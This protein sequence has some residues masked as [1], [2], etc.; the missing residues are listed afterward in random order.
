MR[1][2]FVDESYQNGV[3]GV[4]MVSINVSKYYELKE[5]YLECLNL[6]RWNHEEDIEFK[7]SDIYSKSK[8]DVSVDINSRVRI[9]NWLMEGSK[10]IKSSKMELLFSS[11]KIAHKDCWNF[12]YE[13]VPK[14]LEKTLSGK[15]KK[16]RGR[17]KNICSIFLDKLGSERKNAMFEKKMAE[18]IKTRRFIFFENIF[19]VDS[20]VYTLGIVYA[21][22]IVHL[23]LKQEL[24]LESDTRKKKNIEFFL[25]KLPIIK[26]IN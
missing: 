5:S 8:G 4:C 12:Y 17:H 26:R 20:S 21:D 23:K 2:I 19:Y 24:N 11:K 6:Y 18:I 14:M 9:V 16:G 10:S 13:I 7:A 3:F 25:K 1:L 15:H 22:L